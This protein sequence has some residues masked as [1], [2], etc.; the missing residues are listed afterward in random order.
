MKLNKFFLS[1]LF[2]VSSFGVMAQNYLLNAKSP[3]EITDKG[4]E[5]IMAEAD[6]P[7]PYPHINENDILFSKMVWEKI[8]LDERANLIYYYPETETENR[9]PLFSVLIDAIKN[10][11]ITE[12][13]D[14]DDFSYKLSYED[15]SSKF[16]RTDTVDEGKVQLVM[17]GVVDEQYI[18]TSR[19]RPIDVVEYR[20]KGLWYFDRNAGELKYRI[21]G[22]APVAYDANS[23]LLPE[24]QREPTVLFWLFYPDPNVRNVLFSNYAFNE[25]NPR[26]KINFDYLF[27]ARRFSGT[28]YKVENIQDATISEQVGENAW[29]QLMEAERIKENIRNME[30]DLWSN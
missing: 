28:I 4:I 8:P 9:K 22:I 13:Y 21:L 12:I 3:D 29:F 16:T 7:I 26:K 23:Q 14:T 11:D 20:V 25:K 19:L 27:N 1:A 18:Q 24:D 30:D 2:L 17:E 6:G 10:K 15:I 5:D